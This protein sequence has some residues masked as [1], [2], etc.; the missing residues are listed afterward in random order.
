MSEHEQ[1][2]NEAYIPHI[3]KILEKSV[4]VTRYIRTLEFIETR[5]LSNKCVHDLYICVC[6]AIYVCDKTHLY[7][8]LAEIDIMNNTLSISKLK[9]F[10]RLTDTVLCILLE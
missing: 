9:Q 4:E 5:K 2:F 6:D 10:L 7:E 8:L 1:L 3:D